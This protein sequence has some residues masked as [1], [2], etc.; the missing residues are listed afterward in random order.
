MHS[1]TIK[2]TIENVSSLPVDFLKLTFD[3]S[4]IAPA[5]GLLADGDLPIAEAYETE[6]GLLRKPVFSWSSST[7]GGEPKDVGPGKKVLLTVRCLGKV[8]WYVQLCLAVD[9][10]VIN[11]TH[12]R[13]FSSV[14]GTIQI[15]YSF[16]HT[17]PTSDKFYTRQIL[18]PVLVTVYHTLEC[19]AMDIHPFAPIQAPALR[20]R[21][22]R[23]P[24]PQD[25]EGSVSENDDEDAK[26]RRDLLD[27]TG[28]GDP[29]DW[30]LFTVDVRN[31]YALPFEVHFERKQPNTKPSSTSRLVTPGSTSRIILPIRRIS[32]S[33]ELTSRPIPTLSDRQFVVSKSKMSE[34]Q[35]KVQRELF[36][37]REELFKCVQAKWKEVSCVC[38]RP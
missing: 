30:C 34:A 6:Y 3:D 22:T 37:Y 31:S 4:T 2:L 24:S 16:A 5:Q 10:A 15:A 12:L 17:D 36:W 33:T 28:E 23:S 19:H 21:K 29:E 11:V 35:V 18:Y 8:G 13:Q 1:S 32:L 9:F 27:L 26:T 20:H 7:S 14:N 38:E 25:D